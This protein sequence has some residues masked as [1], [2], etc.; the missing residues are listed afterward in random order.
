MAAHAHE[1]DAAGRIVGYH[2]EGRAAVDI[3]GIRRVGP[4]PD[5]DIGPLRAVRVRR[6]RGMT[7]NADLVDLS[8]GGCCKIAGKGRC[9]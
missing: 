5:E 1:R 8:A 2:I 3:I 6:V 7:E 9:S 4:V